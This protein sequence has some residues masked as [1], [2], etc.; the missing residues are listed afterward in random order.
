MTTLHHIYRKPL[1]QSVQR[2]NNTYYDATENS[3]LPPLGIGDFV[4]A[5]PSL[6][7][8]SGPWLYRLITA[9]PAPRSYIVDT[10][11]GLTRRNRLHLRPAAP[12]APKALIPT[13]WIKQ[14]SAKIPPTVDHSPKLSKPVLPSS[15]P[16]GSRQSTP[17]IPTQTSPTNTALEPALSHVERN[18]QR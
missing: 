4:Y 15:S 10:P 16:K 18:M 7:H 14:L 6:H 17:N 3:S 8:K 2:P 12:P 5:R 11:T 9:I 13:S 1:P